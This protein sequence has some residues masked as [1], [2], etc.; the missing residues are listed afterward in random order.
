[1]KLNGKPPIVTG[2]LP[3]SRF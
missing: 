1:M 2:S 3:I